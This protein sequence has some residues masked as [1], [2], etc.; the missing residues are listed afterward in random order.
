MSHSL[1]NTVTPREASASKKKVIYFRAL[2]EK[3]RFYQCQHFL[4]IFLSKKN[5][6]QSMWFLWQQNHNSWMF[7]G[8]FCHP[9][10][11]DIYHLYFSL[12]YARNV[13]DVQKRQS[14]CLKLWKLYSWKSS[15]FFVS[16][17]VCVCVS[18]SSTNYGWCPPLSNDA[19]VGCNAGI[20]PTL[21]TI[22]FD[23]VGCFHCFIGSTWSCCPTQPKPP[24]DPP[25]ILDTL[26]LK[27]V[28]I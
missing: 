11:H 22:Q 10:F 25:P 8:H 26:L 23:K 6:A 17:F 9:N 4:Q 12:P 14:S 18:F 16:V 2:P 5:S 19:Y 24:S 21:M 27:Y 1:V 3:G 7:I 20:Q 28:S 13:I 15:P